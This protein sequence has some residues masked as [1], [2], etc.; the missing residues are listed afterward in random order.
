[1]P[2]SCNPNMVKKLRVKSLLFAFQASERTGV[3]YCEMDGNR[4]KISGKAILYSISEIFLSE[5]K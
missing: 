3:L 4:V 2:L 1:M 5:S